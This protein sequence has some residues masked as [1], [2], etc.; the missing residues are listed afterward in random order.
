VQ[1]NVLPH[2]CEI[3]SVGGRLGSGAAVTGREEGWRNRHGQEPDE[4]PDAA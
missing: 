3:G 2:L 4:D 1:T